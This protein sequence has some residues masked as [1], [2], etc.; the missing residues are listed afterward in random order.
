MVDSYDVFDLRDAG[1][2]EEALQKGRECHEAN[3][4]DIWAKRALGWTL[5]DLVKSKL[6]NGE[7]G[8][9]RDYIEEFDELE[10]P[11]DEDELIHDKMGQLRQQTTSP[12]L[13]KAKEAS[14][15]EDY[16]KA[17]R[18]FRKARNQTSA[19]DNFRTQNGWALR[20]HIRK[21]VQQDQPPVGLLDRLFREFANVQPPHSQKLYDAILYDAVKIAENWRSYNDFLRWWDIGNL[22]AEHFK[23]DRTQS[24]TYPGLAYKAA[25]A[26]AKRA[27]KDQDDESAEWLL[28]LL[29]K[30]LEH[31]AE[32]DEVWIHYDIGRLANL[33]DDEATA[34]EHL[35]Q[36]VREKYTESWAWGHFAGSFSETEDRKAA[37]CAALDGAANDSFVLSIREELADILVSEEGYP[38]AKREIL[39][40]IEVREAKGY[41]FPERVEQ[42]RN[43]DWMD[44]S[45][46]P[47]SNQ[48]LY[49]AHADR[50][51]ELVLDDI[52]WIDGVV[53]GH[54]EES[55][56]GPART[57]IGVSTGEGTLTDIPARDRNHSLLGS[58][59]EGTPVKVR[60]D[61]STRTVFDIRKREGGNWDLLPQQI[62]VVD[63]VNRESSV[64]HIV[65]TDSRHGLAYHDQ[66][67]GAE[68]FERGD[69]V[70][71]RSLSERPDRPERI[72]TAEKTEEVPPK[73]VNRTFKG[74]FNFPPS[75][76]THFGFVQDYYVP[77]DLIEAHELADGQKI[78]GRAI[79]VQPDEDKWRVVEIKE[80]NPVPRSNH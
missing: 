42:W 39:N 30:I 17:V 24:G 69:Y 75:G 72:V 34:R 21:L 11:E 7:L 64:T 45:E 68:T 50:A 10:I 31:G 53:T 32:E 4:N 38:K 37:L 40:I 61:D 26:G 52:P 6:D 19:D 71:V 54:Q 14:R 33:I 62:A 65:I 67:S 51:R 47:E 80:T 48:P 22:R 20:N 55:D 18:L 60:A 66:V 49:E 63:H 56:K 70:K 44:E 57:F 28:P 9:A 35:A 43:S 77:E 5:Y 25:R 23:P 79:L 58:L 12:A 15:S 16:K 13:R 27:V 46:A 73:T 1:N 8:A 36:V 2:L 3:P 74:T 41:D 76:K 78:Q 29:K 59:E